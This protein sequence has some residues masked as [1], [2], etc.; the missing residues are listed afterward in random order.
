MGFSNKAQGRDQRERTLVSN[1][2]FPDDAGGIAQSAFVDIEQPSWPAD[3]VSTSGCEVV[4]GELGNMANRSQLLF[5]VNAL[6]Q[7]AR[8]PQA[9][10]F[11][12][13]CGSVGAG[14]TLV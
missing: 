4:L 6:G 14:D 12:L 9:D 13:F 7:R 11:L 8:C 10:D 1:Q 5:V 3:G 2:Q